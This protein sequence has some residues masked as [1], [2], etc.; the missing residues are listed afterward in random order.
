VRHQTFRPAC[1]FSAELCSGVA[2]SKRLAVFRVVHCDAFH[3]RAIASTGL[4]GLARISLRV[5][6]ASAS[7][8][9]A[10]LLDALLLQTRQSP[11]PGMN[12]TVRIC[13]NARNARP[14][15]LRRSDIN[16]RSTSEREV[17]PVGNSALYGPGRLMRSALPPITPDAQCDGRKADERL[18][19][20]RESKNEQYNTK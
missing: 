3:K 4:E 17:H 9:R 12:Q 19:F 7:T 8:K 10:W 15:L 5:N 1:H 11:A 14:H 16:R 2:V 18:S 13:H 20:D 6:R